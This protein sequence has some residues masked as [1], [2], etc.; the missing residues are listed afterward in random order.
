MPF[1]ADPFLKKVERLRTLRHRPLLGYS[2]AIASVAVASAARESFADVLVGVRFAPYYIAVALTAVI[3]GGGP[4]LLALGLSLVAADYLMPI[5]GPATTPSGAVATG[6]FLTIAGFILTLIWLLN[7][8]VDRIWHHA[9][10]TRLMIDSQVAGMIGV[11]AEGRIGLVNSAVEK[12]LGYSREEL[13]EKSV[14]ELVPINVR[15]GHADLRKSYMAGPEPRR[16]GAGRDLF[17]V[18]RD[19]SLMPVE[20]GLSPVSNG[21]RIGTVATIVDISERKKHERRAEVLANEVR[22]R[23]RN[24]LTLVQALALRTLPRESASAFVGTLQ[25]LARTQD[26]FGTNTVAPLRKILEGELSGLNT[27][28]RISGCDILLTSDVAQDFSLIVHELTTNALK[29][30]ALSQPN[31]TIVVSG[32]KNAN[33]MFHFSWTERG[34]PPIWGP[35]LRTGFGETIL[36]EI[37]RHM[38]AQT[39]IDYLRDGLRYRLIVPIE[40]ISNVATLAKAAAIA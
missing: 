20:I 33:G 13:L 9:E 14:E 29:H 19:G 26:I 30:G 17:A 16:M 35:P 23:A 27:Q 2:V 1:R 38:H 28:A 5:A 31:G 10:N 4:G 18:T 32:R 3:G 40:R 8:A 21:G 15:G 34:G 12:Q 37:P 22:H 6:L 36:Q 7:H 25:A 11:D 24:L 39:T